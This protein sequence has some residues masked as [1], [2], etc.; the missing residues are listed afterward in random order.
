MSGSA[1]P[2][3]GRWTSGFDEMCAIRWSP[4]SAV[5]VASSTKSVSVG[6][7]PGRNATRRRAPTR[8][9]DVAVGEPHVE[10]R[11]RAAVAPAVAGDREECLTPLG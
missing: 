9:D 1:G 3:G 7:C 6:L 5:P 11:S 10:G 4:A 8:L 2:S